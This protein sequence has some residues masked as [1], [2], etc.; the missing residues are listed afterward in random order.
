MF[1]PGH[2]KMGGRQKGGTNLERRAAKQIIETALQKTIPERLLELCQKSPRDEADILI[3]LMPYCYPKLHAV[4][5][6]A[7]LVHN[8]GDEIARLSAKIL[9]LTTKEPGE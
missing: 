3:A 2:K 5:V 7:H 8:E 6:E 4:D 1:E 9:M